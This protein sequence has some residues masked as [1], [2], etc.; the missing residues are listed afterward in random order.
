LAVINR[1]RESNV[2]AMNSRAIDNRCNANGRFDKDLT[3]TCFCEHIRLS[4]S[5]LM[6]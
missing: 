6:Q 2:K 3:L 4:V 1:K 5:S